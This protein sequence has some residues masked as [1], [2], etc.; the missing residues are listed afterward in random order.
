MTESLFVPLVLAATNCALRA[1]TAA[2]RY[3]WIVLA[4]LFTGLASLT[5]GNGIVLGLALA[6]VVWSVRPRWSWRS[7]AAPALLLVVMALT[8]MPWTIRN[9]NAQHAFIPVTDEIGNTLKGTY[10]DLSAKQRFIWWGH[11]YSN[12]NS[13]QKDKHLTES[14]RN[15]KLISAVIRY[16][17]KHPQYVPEAMFWNTMR[18]FDLQG[19]RVSRMTARTDA[20]AT[21]AFADIGVVCFWIVGLL[22]IAG[23]FTL[24]ARRVPRSLWLAPLVMW[25]SIAPVTTGT[26][27]FRAALDP[28][29]ILLAAFALQACVEA[30]L[31]RRRGAID[32]PLAAG[33]AT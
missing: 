2:H 23:T 21:A 19:R 17:G 28:F 33:A 6:V 5:R 9:A 32:A 25:L 24:A 29:A 14:Q 13:I 16:V 31:R 27:R 26:P 15:S 7:L 12:Y 18:L 22:A 20:D 8:I 30:V 10:N 1:R 4:G 11:G 3:R